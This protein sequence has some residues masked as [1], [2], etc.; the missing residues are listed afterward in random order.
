V[1]VGGN[2][3]PA[4]RRAAYH[5]DG[6][7]GWNLTPEQVEAAIATIDRHL[8]DQGRRRDDSYTLQVGYVHSGSDDD[9]ATYVK[10]AERAGLDRLVL[11]LPMSRRTY[12]A[13]LEY[14]AGVL[15]LGAG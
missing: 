14:Y 3:G 4:L 5:G 13:R 6:W 10:A 1:L 11:A 12:A 8:A 15:A 9:L 7:Y 2:T